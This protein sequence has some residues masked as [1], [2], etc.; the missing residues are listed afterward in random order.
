MGSTLL[1]QHVAKATV[2]S[3][4]G[5][6]VFDSGGTGVAP[7]GGGDAVGS[8]IHGQNQPRHHEHALY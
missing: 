2:G 6:S 5:D 3:G 1:T 7:A 8:V 4:P